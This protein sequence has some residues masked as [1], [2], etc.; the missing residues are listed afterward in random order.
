MIEKR[1]DIPFVA[2]LALC[3]KQI[4]QN[5]RPIIAVHK[6]F[7]R[8]PGSLFRAL[9]LSEFA[10][11]SDVSLQEAYYESH[12]FAGKAVMDPFMG[13]GTPLFE[14]NRLGFDVTGYDI[15]PMAYWVVKQ[16]IEHLDLLAYR[17]MARNIHARMGDRFGDFYMTRCLH[18][19]ELVPFKSCLWVKTC[20]CISCAKTFDLFPGYLLAKNVRHPRNVL[21]CPGCGSLNEVEDR[22]VL[23]CCVHCGTNLSLKGP[24][25]QSSCECPHCGTINRYPRNGEGPPRHRLFAI[26]YH[27]EKCRPKHKGRFFKKPDKE[28]F[29]RF[30]SAEDMLGATGTNF[31]PSDEIP[32]GDETNRLHRWGYRLYQ[33]MFN[34]RQLL[35]LESFCCEIVKVEDKRVRNALATNLSDLLRYQNMLCR[36][37]TMALKCLDIFSVHGF[38]VG[39][40]ECEANL[41]GVY[42]SRKRTIVG[43]GG[44]LNIVDKY[45]RAKAY[46]DEPFET[47]FV[48]NKSKRVTIAGEWIGDQ[49]NDLLGNHKRVLSLRCA[50]AS[51][52]RIRENSLDAVLTDPPYTGNVQYAELMDFCYVWLRRLVGKDFPEF[53]S[54]STR[55]KNELTNN[56]TMDRGMSAY[57][58]GFSDVLCLMAKGLKSN[59]P[60]AFTYHHNSMAAYVPI[61]VAIL[62]SRLSCTA[63]IPCPAEMGA[64]IHIKGTSSS[65]VDS[66]FVC[67]KTISCRKQSGVSAIK[68]IAADV[69]RDLYALRAG[70]VKPTAGDIRSVACA[71]LS[72]SVILRLYDMWDKVKPIESRLLSVEKAVDEFGGLDVVLKHV[73]EMEKSIEASGQLDALLKKDSE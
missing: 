15:N 10:E 57:A 62:D 41:L 39:L 44:W 71:H 12:D 26:E 61:I 66:V 36:Y 30:S 20:I 60:L 32:T 53:D 23:G 48:G 25:K 42:D 2:K 27:C 46:C 38:P 34:S 47:R 52:V 5:Y 21:I 51:R 16:E 33:E 14:A 59:A 28:D 19:Q 6:W 37:D 3:E 70:G 29:A 1:F 13:G 24:A 68:E 55:H 63:V 18:C 45:I 7:A 40:V 31:V 50:D 73:C 9:L 49:R 22:D 8:R 67:R 56:V 65:I 11:P 54:I 58:Q 69:Q 43:S 35:G 64:S 4:Q 17:N 72:K